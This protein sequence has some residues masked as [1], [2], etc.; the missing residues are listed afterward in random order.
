MRSLLRTLVVLGSLLVGGW[1]RPVD[2]QFSIDELEIHVTPN[3]SQAITRAFAIRS[4]I[5]SAQQI[6]LT[7]NDWERDSTG[8]NKI[9]DLG[10]HPRSCSGSVDIFPLTMQLPP[11][12]TEFVRV[13]YTPKAGAETHGCWSIVMARSPRPPTPTGGRQGVS[14]STVIGVKLYV[15][16]PQ[17]TLLAEVISADAETGWKRQQNGDST[18]IRQLAVRL[19]NVG[20]G[21]LRVTSKVE[22][23][24]QRTEMLAQFDGPLAFI[25]PGA[26][27]D[28]LIELPASLPSGR[29]VAV[30]LL[31]YGGEEITAAQIEVEIP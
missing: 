3:G 16:E 12:G 30:V 25:T 29:H 17:E 13:T 7:V 31:D 8:S 1:G 22:L 11:R 14:I 9:L 24:G 18:Q 28:L 21:H 10:S 6:L 26:F 15:H 20:T 4:T 27:R 2:A 23:R 19:A 5:D